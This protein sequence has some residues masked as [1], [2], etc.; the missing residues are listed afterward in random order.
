MI[1]CIYIDFYTLTHCFTNQDSENT[2]RS[3]GFIRENQDL[4]HE[5]FETLVVSPPPYLHFVDFTHFNHDFR[6]FD[7]PPSYENCALEPQ[8]PTYSSI[9][10]NTP[11]IH[12]V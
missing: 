5:T 3:H 1:T 6:N 2:Q 11:S 9:L 7:L 12:V 8:P 4:N 10:I